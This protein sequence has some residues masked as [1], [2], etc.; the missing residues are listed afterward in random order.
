ML[1]NTEETEH[2]VLINLSLTFK[3]YQTMKT[4][5]KTAL[6]SLFGLLMCAIVGLSLDSCANK[7]ES[8][9]TYEEQL[10]QDSLAAKFALE[11][12]KWAS[13][14]DYIKT[15]KAWRERQINDSIVSHLSE[16]TLATVVNV[17]KKTH[18]TFT[19]ADVVAEYNA[20]KDIYDE[21]KSPERATEQFE[22]LPTQTQTDSLE[23][24]TIIGGHKV[25][26]VEYTR[27]E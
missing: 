8:D 15:I 13:A 27:I 20:H 12:T 21:V 11:E 2:K 17:V 26:V 7:S 25:R 1:K 10:E 6:L 14:T 22:K 24:D 5:I 19:N 23:Y 9:T 4:A 3:L 18:S 16:Q